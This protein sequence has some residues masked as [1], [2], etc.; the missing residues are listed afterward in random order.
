MDIFE[1]QRYF[2][3]MSTVYSSC[4]GVSIKMSLGR[5]LPTLRLI[6]NLSHDC[7]VG[8]CGAKQ[9]LERRGH[10]QGP[11]DGLFI[12][13]AAASAL[14]WAMHCTNMAVHG[15]GDTSLAWESKVSLLSDI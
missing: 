2:P 15:L 12:Q 3:A 14:D 11:G 6:V 10:L 5:Q 9:V 7:I 8:R 4:D 1:V 13:D